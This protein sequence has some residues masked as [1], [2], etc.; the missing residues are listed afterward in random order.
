MKF[1][2][3]TYIPLDSQN[4]KSETTPKQWTTKN[5]FIELLQNFKWS[6]YPAS[7]TLSVY[8]P[9]SSIILWV[10]LYATSESNDKMFIIGYH[11]PVMTKGFLG[12]GK[13]KEKEKMSTY[14][15]V[16]IENVKTVFSDYFE[17]HLEKMELALEKYNSEVK[18]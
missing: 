2:F 8:T 6:D 15:V 13:L 3:D 12:L 16:G 1:Q 4:S 17:A 9:N 5:E 7:P 10:S 14:F 18:M 11:R